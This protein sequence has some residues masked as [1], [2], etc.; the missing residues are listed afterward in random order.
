MTVLLVDDDPVMLRMLKTKI[1][2][3]D[4]GISTIRTADNGADALQ[5]LSELQVDFAFVDMKM[6]RMPGIEG[7][8]TGP[9]GLPSS[10]KEDRPGRG[11]P[12]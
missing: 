1:P 2:W 4:Y 12:P 10:R 9:T 6:P 8:P 3:E 11:D 7:N 5:I